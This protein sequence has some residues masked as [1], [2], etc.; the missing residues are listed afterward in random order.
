MPSGLRI[1]RGEDVYGKEGRTGCSRSQ[2]Y[3]HIAE[4]RAPPGFMISPQA[5]GW[6]EHDIDAW[7]IARVEKGGIDKAPPATPEPYASMVGHN[8]GPP[9]KRRRGRPRKNAT[10]PGVFGGPAEGGA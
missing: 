4:G 2:W 1:L 6:L 9:M 10:P 3:R 7:I 5:R 8:G